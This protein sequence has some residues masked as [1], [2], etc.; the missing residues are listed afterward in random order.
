MIPYMKLK[1][2][3]CRLC[4]ECRGTFYTKFLFTKEEEVNTSNLT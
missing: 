1:S 3:K 2:S 4:N